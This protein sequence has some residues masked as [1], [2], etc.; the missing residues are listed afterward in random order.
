MPTYNFTLPVVTVRDP[1]T[2]MQSM[3]RQNYAA[4]FDHSK[5]NCPNIVPYPRDIEAHPRYAHMKYIPIHIKYDVDYRRKYES[6]P[7]LW[8]EWYSVYVNSSFPLL[9]VR[10]EDLVFHAERILPKVC[11]CAGFQYQGNF[12]PINEIQNKNHGIEQNATSQGLLRSILTYGNVTN[13][14][15]GYPLFQLEAARMVLSD[16]LMERFNYGY[17][18]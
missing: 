18:V 6:L 16:H 10:M 7:H 12:R 2:W 14:R 11:E 5:A 1:Y 9:L 3:C 15:A 17:E 13:R 4:Q 8:N